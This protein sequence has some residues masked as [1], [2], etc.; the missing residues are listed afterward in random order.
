MTA[1]R[2]KSINKKVKTDN[3]K[4]SFTK[5]QNNNKKFQKKD[6]KGKSK[7]QDKKPFNKN[8]KKSLKNPDTKAN[9]N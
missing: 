8:V 6:F 9:D 1:S 3:P 4:K 7:S 5:P 2:E